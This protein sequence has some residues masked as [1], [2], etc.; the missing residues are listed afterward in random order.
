[1]RIDKKDPK[2]ITAQFLDRAFRRLEIREKAEEFFRNNSARIVEEALSKDVEYVLG[3]VHPSS[4]NSGETMSLP[5]RIEELARGIIK[6]VAGSVAEFQMQSM[7]AAPATGFR[8]SQTKTNENPSVSDTATPDLPEVVNWTPSNI[9]STVVGCQV[10]LAW[11]GKGS[12]PP[13]PALTVVYDEEPVS[14]GVKTRDAVSI[15]ISID[16]PKPAR[17]MIEISDAG[18]YVVNL[19]SS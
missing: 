5:R 19:Y 2:H 12:P 18:E 15:E 10:F 1:M 17:F 6:A 8:R 11:K 14:F 3:S 7:Q 13:R 4:G 16:Q 9:S